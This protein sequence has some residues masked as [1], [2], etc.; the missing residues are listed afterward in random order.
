MGSLMIARPGMISIT[1]N[2]EKSYGGW[3]LKPDPQIPFLRA[4]NV[5]KNGLGW[6]FNHQL[7]KSHVIWMDVKS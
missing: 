6:F 7:N 5:I 3:F 1:S 2:H 4:K